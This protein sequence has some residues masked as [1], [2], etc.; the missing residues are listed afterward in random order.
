[1]EMKMTKMIIVDSK[2]L[3]DSISTC[4]EPAD[5]AIRPHVALL[6]YDFERHFICMITWV[7]GALNPA[8]PLTKPDSP[9]MET[10]NLMLRDGR[11]TLSVLE[12]FARSPGKSL[13]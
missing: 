7:R 1:M 8:D 3:W 5:R 9:Q 12:E 10:L 6:R 2:T 13:G 4:H 11:L